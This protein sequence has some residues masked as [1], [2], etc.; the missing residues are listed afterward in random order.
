MYDKRR[1][2]IEDLARWVSLGLI[3]V[4]LV[5]TLTADAGSRKSKDD[6]DVEPVVE[7]VTVVE[8]NIEQEVYDI[9]RI[10]ITDSGFRTQLTSILF[11]AAQKYDLEEYVL[12]M[13]GQILIESSGNPYAVG[14]MVCL[15]YEEDEETCSLYGNAKGLAQIMSVYWKY[16]HECSGN[17]FIPRNNLFCQAFVLRTMLNR[18]NDE[19]LCA[20]NRYWGTT[21]Y[22][23]EPSPYT[24]K[25][26]EYV[27]TD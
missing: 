16:H 14:P 17:L 15:E 8:Q 5:F 1:K 10:K 2:L 13:A 19:V 3:T 27:N 11:D 21:K 24:D 20:L 22:G 26:L 9:F 18:C 23:N 6:F 4:L 7:Q 12:H 25:V